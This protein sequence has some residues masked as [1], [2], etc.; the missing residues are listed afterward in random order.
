MNKIL[1]ICGPTATG[2]T[3]LAL[4][5]ADKFNGELVSADSRQVYK[6][7]DIGTGKGLPRISNF[8]FPISN[9]KKEKI[10]CFLVRGV[11]IW[12]YDLV[13]PDESFSVSRYIDLAEK[14]INNIWVR[15]KLPIL[16]GG[17]GLYIKGVV[18]GI[19]TSAI[20]PNEELRNSLKAKSADEMFEILAT[21]D[22]IRSASINSSDKKN[23]RRLLRAIEIARNVNKLGSSKRR[24]NIDSLFVGL[25]V[26]KVVLEKKI[27]KRVVERIN[28][29]QEEE[30]K[31]LLRM[32]VTWEMQSMQAFGYKQWKE[33]FND[34]LP[35]KEVIDRWSNSEI[36]YAKRQVT[37]F[38]KDARIHW[39]DVIDNNFEKDI[40][41]LVEKW[42]NG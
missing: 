1:V 27:K 24:T 21:I 31:K 16:V 40:E 20:P 15:G 17:T 3:E 7:M 9:L 36:K 39:F 18:D 25:K 19:G 37:W 35:R 41:N 34:E 23:P 8:Q 4:R 29:G 5:L 33:Y 22:P 38:K 13:K 30:I 2:K 42:Q 32:G 6:G 11:P 26:P 10:G 28:F 14:I 12:G